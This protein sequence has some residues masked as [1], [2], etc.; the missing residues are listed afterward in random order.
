MEH[1]TD[2]DSHPDEDP[3]VTAVRDGD[4]A[5]WQTLIERYEG[6]LLAFA[7]SRIGD[8]ESSEDI[9]QETFIGFL[10]S[11]PNYDSRRPLAP[12]RDAILLPAPGSIDGGSD[13]ASM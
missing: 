3:L 11:L 9:V 2:E 13:R 12:T 4:A 7:R 1:Q 5:A 8:R 10:T 6:R